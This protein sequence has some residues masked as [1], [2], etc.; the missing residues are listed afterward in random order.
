MRKMIITLHRQ[1]LRHPMV[2]DGPSR[3]MGHQ[4]VHR[5][6]TLVHGRPDYKK[7]GV[8]RQLFPEVPIIALTA[9]ATERVRA[10]LCSILRVSGC[11][12]FH[13]SVDR[14]NLFYEVRQHTTMVRMSSGCGS[15]ALCQLPYL[16]CEV[17]LLPS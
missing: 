5:L 16:F 10:D 11:E 4:H 12:T 14:P 13:S 7:L 2:V 6:N 1:K 9:T 15:P 3:Y 17:C 8:L